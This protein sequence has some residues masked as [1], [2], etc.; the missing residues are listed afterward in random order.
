MQVLEQWKV[1]KYF[2]EMAW[3][4]CIRCYVMQYFP[5]KKWRTQAIVYK[6]AVW[7]LAC[8]VMLNPEITPQVNLAWYSLTNL[9]MKSESLTAF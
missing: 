6:L 7:L 1:F 2:K 8:V 5:W 4:A 3:V 9:L